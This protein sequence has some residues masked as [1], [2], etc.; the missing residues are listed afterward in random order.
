MYTPPNKRKLPLFKIDNKSFPQ[1]QKKNILTEPKN[2]IWSDFK[3]ENLH[4]EIKELP[5]PEEKPEEIKYDTDEDT[6]DSDVYA[7]PN[8]EE[9]SS[10]TIILSDSDDY[11]KNNINRSIRHY[12]YI[13]PN[14]DGVSFADI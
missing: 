10:D 1:L 5:K 9:Y 8:S 11:T 13:E 7:P 6:D 3:K 14:E 2:T 12:N 4:G